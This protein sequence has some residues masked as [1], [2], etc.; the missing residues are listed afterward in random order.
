MRDLIKYLIMFITGLAEA[1][2]V[3]TIGLEYG[4]WE[5]W[6]ISMPTVILMAL[7]LFNSKSLCK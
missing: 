4:D 6:A 7:F 3:G 1:H 2:L 5:F